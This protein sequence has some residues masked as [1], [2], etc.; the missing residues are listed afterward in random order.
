MSEE[1]WVGGDRGVIEKCWNEIF[2]EL[3]SPSLRQEHCTLMRMTFPP[4]VGRS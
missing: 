3:L 1:N 2:G 4:L